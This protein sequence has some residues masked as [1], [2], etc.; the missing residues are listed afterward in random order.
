MAIEPANFRPKAFPPPEFPPK[1]LP[2][3]AKMPPA[4]FPVVLGLLGLVLALKRATVELGQGA[5]LAELAMGLAAGLWL[6][7]AVAYAIKL[8][9][10]PAVVM[11]DLRILPGRAGLSAA[12]VGGF[13][14]SA[15]LSLFSPAAAGIALPLAFALHTGLVILTIR[16]ILAAPPEAR[17]VTPVWHLS[18][19]GYIVGALAAAQ[20]GW[21]GVAGNILYISIGIAA[22]IWLYSLWQLFRRI[23]P[24]PLRPLLSIHLSPAALFASVAGLLG[25]TEL[26]LV[27][28]A[29]GVVILIAM[30]A[31]GRWITESGFSPMWGAFTF[32]VAAYASALM[33]NGFALPGIALTAVVLVT[34]TMIAWRVLKM[35]PKGTL[36]SKTN[37]AAA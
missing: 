6:F 15:V 5:P 34:N 13:A 14:F 24:A 25:L 36:A 7:C 18:F 23:P 30:V 3:F 8:S 4:V 22:A 20:L 32:P 21:T 35:W 28:L 9:R 19:V 10:R 27:F 17:D 12:T 31:F 1:R 29:L 11:E 16:S 2:L 33:I 26:A 37:A